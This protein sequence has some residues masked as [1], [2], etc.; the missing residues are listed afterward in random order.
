MPG[1][2]WQPPHPRSL[3]SAAPRLGLP[4]TSSRP[5]DA[6]RS[7]APSVTAM[8]ARVSDRFRPAKL[9]RIGCSDLD[10]LVCLKPIFFLADHLLLVETC[11]VGTFSTSGDTGL[12]EERH[13]P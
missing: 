12:V 4:R 5:G 7:Q 6:L 10:H 2:S 13:H 11:A 8:T 1:I 3:T 9:P